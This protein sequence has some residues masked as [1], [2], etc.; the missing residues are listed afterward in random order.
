MTRCTYWSAVIAAAIEHFYIGLWTWTWTRIYG[1]RNRL[2]NGEAGDVVGARNCRTFIGIFQIYFITHTDIPHPL[3]PPT[4]LPVAPLDAS[5]IAY[6]RSSCNRSSGWRFQTSGVARCNALIEFLWDSNRIPT[7][8]AIDDNRSV[9]LSSKVSSAQQSISH[10]YTTNTKGTL[11][12][13]VSW[14]NASLSS[15]RARGT[16]CLFRIDNILSTLTG[17]YNKIVL[18][19]L[20]LPVLT[21]PAWFH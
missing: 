7:P 17:R 2:N 13:G 3:S 19:V 20:G 11:K 9:G 5:N 15:N 18:C 6:R 16:S 1:H 14:G 12:D 21:L 4:Y 10:S 8:T